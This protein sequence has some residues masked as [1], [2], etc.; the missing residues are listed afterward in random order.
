MRMMP[1]PIRPSMDS[2]EWNMI[3]SNT[4]A[5]TIWVYIPKLPLDAVSRWR[6]MVRNNCVLKPNRLI[7]IINST[8]E[9]LFGHTTGV[10]KIS[11]PLKDAIQH[12]REKKDIEWRGEA[13]FP[14][15]R[16]EQ[17]ALKGAQ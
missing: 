14:I 9:M 8:H 5:K 17:T 12:H 13:R 16:M 10:L 6:P 7:V 15:A 4:S 1:V 2:S 3:L 11:I